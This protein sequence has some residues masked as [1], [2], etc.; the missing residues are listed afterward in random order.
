MLSEKEILEKYGHLKLVIKRAEAEIEMMQ[1]TVT[2]I[3]RKHLEDLD[4]KAV[5]NIE[6]MG[7][8]SLVRRKN[9]RYSDEVKNEEFLLREKFPLKLLLRMKILVGIF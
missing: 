3:A 2:K 7:V 8:L 6:G 9:W 5:L 4:E 1:D